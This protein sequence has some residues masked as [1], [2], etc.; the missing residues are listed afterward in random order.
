MSPVHTSPRMYASTYVYSWTA[1]RGP[2]GQAESR[3]GVVGWLFF[4][5][6]CWFF[7]QAKAT[8][9]RRK[10]CLASGGRFPWLARLVLEGLQYFHVDLSA[11]LSECC[12]PSAVR[13]RLGKPLAGHRLSS[14]AAFR[15]PW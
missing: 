3:T 2:D 12:S 9:E 1:R 14:T 15:Y 11:G 7:L 13:P 4:V 5:S 6:F 10:G 8:E